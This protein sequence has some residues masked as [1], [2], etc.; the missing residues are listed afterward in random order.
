LI[1]WNTFTLGLRETRNLDVDDQPPPA[2]AW[3]KVCLTKGS[4]RF[5]A[6]AAMFSFKEASKLHRKPSVKA[7][8]RLPVS[9]KGLCNASGLEE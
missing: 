3:H 2:N 5:Y 7:W 8:P 9:L 1:G 4:N 6:E